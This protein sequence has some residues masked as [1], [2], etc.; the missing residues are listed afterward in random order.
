ML[1]GSDGLHSAEMY[2]RLEKRVPP[3]AY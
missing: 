2:P 3:Y 1:L